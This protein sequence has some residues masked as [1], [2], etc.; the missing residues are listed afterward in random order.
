MSHP[1]LTDAEI[2]AAKKKA[3]VRLEAQAKK[4][5]LADI[6][7]AEVERLKMEEGLVPGAGPQDEMVSI[8][9]DL[10]EHS[11][12]IVID[13]T[14]YCHGRTYTLPRHKADTLRD[15]MYQGWRHQELEIDGKKLSQFYAKKR[16]TVLSAKT[17]SALNAPETR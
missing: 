9:L 1:L 8:T 6:E 12:R 3:R 11:D 2:L 14:I 7:D 4:A 5:A 10:A 15:I 13:G 16:N 17:G